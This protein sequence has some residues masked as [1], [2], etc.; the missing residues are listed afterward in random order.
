MAHLV[1][2]VDTSTD[3]QASPDAVSRWFEYP[4][5]LF[6]RLDMEDR[7]RLASLFREAAMKEPEG[8]W[9]N[10]LLE[11]PNGFGLDDDDEG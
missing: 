8:P 3:E 7:H 5:Y 4:A 10:A 2:A 9:R 6:D 11:V 1:A